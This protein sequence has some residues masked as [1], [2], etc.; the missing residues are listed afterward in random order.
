[1]PTLSDTLATHERVDVIIKRLAN[2]KRTESTLAAERFRLLTELSELRP[3]DP[4]VTLTRDAK[5][6]RRE[7]RDTVNRHSTIADAPIFADALATGDIS[8]AHI[9]GLTRAFKILGDDKT[10]LIERL[11]SLINAAS[12]MNADDFDRHAK[13]AA[14]A[15]VSDGGLSRLEQQRRE[16]HFKMW[17]DLDGNLQVRGQ[18]DPERGAIFQNLVSQRVEAM[19]HSGDLDIRLDV[20]PGIEPNHHRNALALLELIRGA[21]TS[22]ITSDRP[23]RA[24]LVV[25]VDLE[26]L[27]NRIRSHETS[28]HGAPGVCRSSFGGELPIETM[29]RIACDADIIPVVLDGRSVPLDVGRAKRLA[30]AHQRRALESAH[31]TC[32]IEACLV[33]Y[34]HCSIHHIEYWEN[35]GST[36]LNNM[37]P[38]CS[39]HHHKAHEGGWKLS[40]NPDTREL[41]VDYP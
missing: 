3:I 26:T 5:L 7:A 11:P 31:E 34:H 23:V 39:K 35:G 25:H 15:L 13:D 40:L 4:E 22:V 8:V 37:I 6:S 19:F 36:D 38:L 14:K 2:I 9:D 24:E 12:H 10:A 29:R 21:G 33:P 32:A 20:A 28:T 17:N 30:T 1:M 27:Q 41:T 16:T 18:F